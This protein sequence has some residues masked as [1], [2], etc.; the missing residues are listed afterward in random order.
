MPDSYP[1]TGEVV[2][3]DRVD[4]SSATYGTIPSQGLI[5]RSQDYSQKLS[6]FDALLFSLFV[7]GVGVLA[8]SLGEVRAERREQKKAQ[9]AGVGR[10]V[11]DES[12]YT[13]FVYGT[14][15]KS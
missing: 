5:P 4:I 6:G 1:S 15:P 10:W 9:A 8:W 12:G 7:I 11:V 14:V 2:L 13:D 3:S